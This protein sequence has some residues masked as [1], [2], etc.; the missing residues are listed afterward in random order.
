[1]E[2]VLLFVQSAILRLYPRT[3]VAI[4]SDSDSTIMSP[5]R[6]FNQCPNNYS[7]TSGS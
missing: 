3:A 7:L 5:S 4:T 2:E 1:M 6:F